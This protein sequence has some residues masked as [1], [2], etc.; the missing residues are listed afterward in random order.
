V[1][2]QVEWLLLWQ[3]LAGGL[4]PGQQRE[5]FARY[6]AV[7]GIGG[8]RGKWLPPEVQRETLRLLA[9]L[10]H[11]PA[12]KRASLGDELLARLRKDRRSASLLWALGRAGARVPLHGPLNTVVPPARAQAWITALLEL[13]PISETLAATVV[14]LAERT[15]DAARDL[16]EGFCRGVHERLRGHDLS[17]GLLAALLEPQPPS[18]RTSALAYGESLPEGLRLVLPSVDRSGPPS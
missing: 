4:S 16:D 12:A 7:A 14:R 2:C 15:G 13:L 18:D 11:V 6:A 9:S 5:L 3:R 17:A 8:K 10:E 1:Q